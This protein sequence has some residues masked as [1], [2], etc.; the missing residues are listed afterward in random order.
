VDVAHWVPLVRAQIEADNFTNKPTAETIRAELKE[1]GAW[2]A[3]ELS[4]DDDNFSRLVWCAACNV[5]DE[6]KPDCSEPV[7]PKPKTT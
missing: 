3:A 6:P 7:K 4:N 1:Y 5:N 2:D